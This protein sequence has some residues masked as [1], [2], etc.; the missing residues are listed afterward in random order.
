MNWLDILLIIILLLSLMWGIRTGLVST[1]IYA[2]SLL[3]GSV[4][5]GQ[6]SPN[7]GSIASEQL[8]IGFS[9][10]ILTTAS[11]ALI[12]VGSLMVTRLIVK[13]LKPANTLFDIL[14][15]GL[16]RILGA[17]IGVLAGIILVFITISGLSSLTYNIALAAVIVDEIPVT[18]VLSTR[19]VIETALLESSFTPYIIT[20]LKVIPA[21]AMGAIPIDFMTS[22]EILDSK[23]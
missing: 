23:M 22:I 9:S 12:M 19:N 15:L 18:G 13:S 5:A 10:E 14:T 20:L 3:V 21:N 17:V 16:N 11:Y 4:L 2:V 1:G 7:I 8:H 6:I